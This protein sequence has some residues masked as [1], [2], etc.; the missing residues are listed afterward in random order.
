MGACRDLQMMAAP[1]A[2]SR[3]KLECWP[4]AGAH[5]TDRVSRRP[6]DDSWWK[7]LEAHHGTA[8]VGRS[9]P[10]HGTT[11]GDPCRDLQ[12]MAAPNALCRGE[13]ECW[14]TACEHAAVSRQVLVTFLRRQYRCVD[15]PR[16]S[17]RVAHR[18]ACVKAERPCFGS[19]NVGTCRDPQMMAAPNAQSR[20]KLECGLTAGVHTTD[21]VSRR[22]WHRLVTTKCRVS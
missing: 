19:G 2:Q 12:M 13:P 15:Q 22:P 17:A 3:G 5:A 8:Q 21:R 10:C 11:D 4:T 20:G 16:R 14:T 7:M 9:G 1:N 18:R 6:C